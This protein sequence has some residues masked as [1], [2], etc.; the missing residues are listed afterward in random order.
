M[1][2]DYNLFVI[3]AGPGGLA[4]AKK[5][6]SYGVRV[7][8]AEQ[9]SIGGTCVNRGCIPK[10]L[11]VYAADFALQKQIAPSY[12]WSECQTYFDW[13]LF[14]KSVHQH[15]DTL[16]QTYFQQL[17]KAGI[18][19]ICDRA[20][21]IDAHTV[22]INGLKVTA[23]KILIAVGGQPLKPK[24][25]GI[26]YAIT[27]RE[28][29]QLPYLPKRLAIIGG[30][31]IGVEFSSMMHAFGCQVTM[32]EKDE[33]ILSGFDDDIRSSVQQGLRKRGIKLLTS[34]TVQEIKYSDESLLLTITGKKRE[35][36]TA[37]TILVATGY[38]PN[39]KNLGLEN[40]HVELGEHGAIKVDEYSRT[41]QE[42]IFAVGD[43]TS[44]VQLSPVAK[45]EG[46]AFANTVFGNKVQKLDYDYVPSAV[47][48]RPEAA[49]VGMTEAKAREKFGE[50]V[51]C[52]YTQFQPL[53]Y[54]ITE[55]NELTTMKL[56][57][58]GDSGQVL[59]AHLVGEHAADIIQS[60]G[61]AIRKGIT[62]EDLDEI[63]G[64][65][66]T[67]GEEFFSLNQVQ[68]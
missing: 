62:K 36:I 55:Q 22:D 4:A 27:S 34:S 44:R 57:L 14:I 37:D 58:N 16:N 33:M 13:T 3:G 32:I 24:I 61:V 8:I 54:Q 59:G 2:F 66:P 17:H 48:C 52:Y 45:A 30:G 23:D 67:V 40:V 35:I 49:G 64:I 10:K 47:F 42:N 20:T 60:L 41:S 25:P 18:E 56:V 53:L 19:L 26:E 43:C 1:A 39:T 21:F 38:A 29:F 46:I 5:A 15:L 6:A 31:Y 65:H 11:I 12:G 68:E 50:S 28:M 9:E 63:I 7:A 51:Q